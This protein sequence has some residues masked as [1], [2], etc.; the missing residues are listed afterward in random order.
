M[1]NKEFKMNVQYHV[2]LYTLG[3]FHVC[4][5]TFI[6]WATFASNILSRYT[7]AIGSILMTPSPLDRPCISSLL[8]PYPSSAAS[9]SGAIGKIAFDV[10]RDTARRRGNSAR[11]TKA[12]SSSL[13]H[14]G[15]FLFRSL[16]TL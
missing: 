1:F 4:I 16:S 11:Q 3:A 14:P 10:S 2:Y 12:L 8:S 15:C 6:Q 5:L 9:L 13:S 7:N